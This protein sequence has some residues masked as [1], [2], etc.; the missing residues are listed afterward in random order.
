[1]VRRSFGDVLDAAL[2]STGCAPAATVSGAGIATPGVFGAPLGPW[3]RSA[4]AFG[5]GAAGL[6]AAPPP[7]LSEHRV[8]EPLLRPGTDGER[9]AWRRL[10]DLGAGLPA[11]F[12]A[13][14]LKRAFRRLARQLHPDVHPGLGAGAR[15]DL[16]RDFADARDAYDILLAIGRSS[17]RDA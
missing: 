10:Q 5:P 17:G 3:W 6:P 13:T 1:M 4:S 14:H 9:R 7:P 8:A 12:T 15:A 2:D 11:A 16:C